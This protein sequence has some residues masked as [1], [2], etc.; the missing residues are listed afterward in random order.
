MSIITDRIREKIDKARSTGVYVNCLFID[1][2]T[3]HQLKKDCGLRN[4]DNI[5]DY[6]GLKVIQVFN[7]DT[8]NVGYIHE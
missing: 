6:L 2:Y 8:I 3:F 7:Y 4:T 1:I 5:S